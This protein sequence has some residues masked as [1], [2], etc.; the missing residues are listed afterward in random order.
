MASRQN[1]ALETGLTSRPVF[2]S[3][4]DLDQTVLLAGGKSVEDQHPKTNVVVTVVRIVVVAIGNTCILMIVVPR[5]AAKA[6]RLE[7]R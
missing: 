6:L 7:P 5:A 3:T 2:A 4:P 1:R